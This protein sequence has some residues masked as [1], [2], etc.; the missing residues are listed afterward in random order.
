MSVKNT[1]KLIM[2][3]NTYHIKSTDKYLLRLAIMGSYLKSPM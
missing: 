3:K 1:D 2:L